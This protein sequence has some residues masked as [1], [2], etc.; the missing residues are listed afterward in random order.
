MVKDFLSSLIK[1]CQDQIVVAV[2]KELSTDLAFINLDSHPNINELPH[3][4][5]LGLSGFSCEV[6]EG[7]HIVSC[8]FC[9]MTVRDINMFRHYMI[10]DQLYRALQP[11]KI[12]GYYDATTTDYLGWMVVAD[13]TGLH[14]VSRSET[15]AL[16][17]V[18]ATFLVNPAAVPL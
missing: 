3:V 4:D 10:L 8:A 1:F 12:I 5:L 17:M 15:R 11:E 9:V 2:E 18:Q 16:Q 13:G 7:F 6:N 14:P